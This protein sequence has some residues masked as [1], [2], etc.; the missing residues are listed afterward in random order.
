MIENDGNYLHLFN[1]I[2]ELPP[3]NLMRKTSYNETLKDSSTVKKRFPMYSVESIFLI[4]ILRS[5]E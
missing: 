4:R 3:Y 2:I 1:D 5:K